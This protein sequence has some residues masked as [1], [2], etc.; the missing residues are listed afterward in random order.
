MSRMRCAHCAAFC[1]IDAATSL[2][3]ASL[4]ALTRRSALR[5]TPSRQ[6]AII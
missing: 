3:S 2:R 5:H 4:R 6:P 1:S